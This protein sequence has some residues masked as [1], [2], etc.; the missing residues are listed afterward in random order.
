MGVHGFVCT[1]DWIQ[2]LTFPKLLKKSCDLSRPCGQAASLSTNTGAKEMFCVSSY[3]ESFPKFST[4]I[5]PLIGQC[6]PCHAILLSEELII[7]LAYKL[8]MI[9]GVLSC[10]MWYRVTGNVD[11]GR[12]GY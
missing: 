3:V 6:L 2:G 7:H 1:L 10:G 5:L 12:K 11:A 4:K 9:R 8:T